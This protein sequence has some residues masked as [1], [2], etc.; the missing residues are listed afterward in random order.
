M[1]Y[2]MTAIFLSRAISSSRV[3]LLWNIVKLVGS[4]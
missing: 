3:G 4:Y 2:D 1:S